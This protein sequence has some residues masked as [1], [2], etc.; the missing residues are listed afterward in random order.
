MSRH[1]GERGSLRIHAEYG[2]RPAGPDHDPFLFAQAEFPAIEIINACYLVG[3]KTGVGPVFAHFNHIL[4]QGFC[5]MKVIAIKSK[6]A[7]FLVNSSTSPF[8]VLPVLAIN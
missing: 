5:D 1:S 2:F 8:S 6:S 7:Y 4:L 3:A